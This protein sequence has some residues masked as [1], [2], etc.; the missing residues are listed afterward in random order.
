MDPDDEFL[1]SSKSVSLIESIVSKTS[2]SFSVIS[3]QSSSEFSIIGSSKIHSIIMSVYSYQSQAMDQTLQLR[4]DVSSVSKP[5]SAIHLDNSSR[6]ST[7]ENDRDVYAEDIVMQKIIF[8]ISLFSEDV[9]NRLNEMRSKDYLG[10]LEVTHSDSAAFDS[11]Y[12]MI[13]L[14]DVSIDLLYLILDTL[15]HYELFRLCLIIC[16]RYDLRDRVSRYLVSIGNKYSNLKNFKISFLKKFAR[17]QDIE[18]Q[19]SYSL[20]AHEAMHNVLSIIEKDFLKVDDYGK[21][22][23]NL[24]DNCFDQLFLQGFWRKMVFLM[25]AESALE[26]TYATSDQESFKLLYLVYKCGVKDSEVIKN[27]IGS[28]DLKAFGDMLSKDVNE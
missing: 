14:D 11:Q 19:K 4:S 6:F 5:D 2:D 18:I 17:K 16:N 13:D 7:I 15:E 22:L 26:L 27:I 10:H 1:Q 28:S 24:R 25:D 9:R 8:Y 21:S 20:I 12:M 3:G 23:L